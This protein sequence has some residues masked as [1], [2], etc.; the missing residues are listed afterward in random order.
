MPVSKELFGC[1]A[2][3]QRLSAGSSASGPSERLGS[4]CL[5][6][7]KRDAYDISTEPATPRD[8]VCLFPRTEG[9]RTAFI[10]WAMVF[11]LAVGVSDYS[12]IG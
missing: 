5:N 8:D 3:R 4:L 12:A 11:E 10:Q 1:C 6:A 7:G 9:I 2:A